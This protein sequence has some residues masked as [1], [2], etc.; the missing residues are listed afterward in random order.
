MPTDIFLLATLKAEI[1]QDLGFTVETL[2]TQLTIPQTAKILDVTP[3]TLSIWRC[4]GRHNLPFVKTGK[5]VKYRV[6][7]VAEFIASH[8]FTHTAQVAV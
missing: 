8:R 4:L 3:N 2:P 7:D 5:S 1:A 6:H